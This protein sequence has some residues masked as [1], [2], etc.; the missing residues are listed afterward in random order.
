MKTWVKTLTAA[1]MIGLVA[2]FSFP[3]NVSDP[4]AQHHM[5]DGATRSMAD[6]QL[7]DIRL[8][9]AD[10]KSVLFS[11]ELN[12]GRAVV[13]NFIFSTCTTICPESSGIF[14]QLQSNLRNDIDKVHLVSISIDPQQDTPAVLREYAKKLG[15]GKD[16]QF[17]TGT[18]AS[19]V[20]VQ[21][22]F[23]VYRGDKMNHTQVTLLR[24][25]P[26][27]RWLRID[28]VASADDLLRELHGMAAVK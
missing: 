9:R 26:G 20:A 1:G 5:V 28:G 15:A 8:V 11:D 23:N 18:L 7:P 12:D 22:A 3:H 2:P 14:M 19:S 25:A 16:W 13:L 17:Y 6:Y 10:G 24:A 27:K 4:H 21:R